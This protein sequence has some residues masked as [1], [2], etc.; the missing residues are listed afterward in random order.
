MKNLFKT[1]KKK[2]SPAAWAA[3]DTKLLEYF[4]KFFQIKCFLCTCLAETG[5][6]RKFLSNILKNFYTQTFSIKMTI[7][8]KKF[9]CPSVIKKYFQIIYKYLSK[10]LKLLSFSCSIF[11]AYINRNIWKRKQTILT[12]LVSTSKFFKRHMYI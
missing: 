8:I 4:E 12:I 2:I 5:S 11:Y 7:F 1:A 6:K 9:D 10:Y 3:G